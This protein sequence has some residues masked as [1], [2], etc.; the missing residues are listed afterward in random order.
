M[1]LGRRSFMVAIA[2]SSAGVTCTTSDVLAQPVEKIQIQAD[3]FGAGQIVEGPIVLQEEGAAQDPMATPAEE[4]AEELAVIPPADLPEPNEI[5]LI[6]LDGTVVTGTLSIPNLEMTTE[7]GPMVVPID[8]VRQV[9]PGLSTYS[10]LKEKL[11]GLVADLAS[12]LFDERE[13]A[14]KELIAYGPKISKYLASLTDDG[15]SERQNRLKQIREAIDE[16]Q[17]FSDEPSDAFSWIDGDT[18]VTDHFTIVGKIENQQFELTSRYGVLTVSLADVDYG[19][20]EWGGRGSASKTIKLAQAN[21]VQRQMQSSGIRVERGDR[22][23]VK[24]EGMFNL[25]PWGQQSGPDGAPQ[26]GTWNGTHPVGS[27]VARI[28]NGEYIA[29]GADETFTA[30]NAGTLTFGIAMMDNFVNQGYDWTG[31]YS[32]RLRVE[33]Q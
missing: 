6:L 7:F 19:T 12:E 5:R 32:L 27:V 31:E 11:D 16:Q 9:R 24:A 23:S 13:A 20:R 33:P 3:V 2:L 18:I 8:R 30:P 14:Q 28:G 10:D 29:V 15:D 26:C 21:F 25:V 4:P 17:E 22:I 1:S